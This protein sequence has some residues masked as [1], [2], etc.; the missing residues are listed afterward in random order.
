MI[1]WPFRRRSRTTFKTIESIKPP[2]YIFTGHDDALR[3]RTEARRKAAEGLRT[4]AN[5]VDSG[6]AV[7]NILRRVK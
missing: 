2:T 4:R 1:W 3:Q 7:S 6:E 5:H